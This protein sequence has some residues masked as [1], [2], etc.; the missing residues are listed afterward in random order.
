VQIDTAWKIDF[1]PDTLLHVHRYGLPLWEL[2]HLFFTHSH[3]DHMDV[4]DLL[5]MVP[6][7][8]H[9]DFG[10]EPLN[11]YLSADAAKQLTAQTD[12][13]MLPIELHLLRPFE[14]VHAGAL[15]A[16]PVLAAHNPQE[17]CLF[18]VLEKDGKTVL[19]ASD[20]GPFPEA[21]WEFL[22]TKQFDLVI[23]ECT[24]G[25]RQMHYTG[26]MGLPNVVQIRERLLTAGA[27]TPATPCW[28]THFSHNAQITHDEFV[29]MAA[30]YGIDV[31]YDGVQLTV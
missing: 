12:G 20:T 18:Y 30:P 15:T 31:A 5:M 22:L 10:N 28:I 16:T 8:G 21:T 25:A 29:Q 23:T 9:N 6:P 7:F 17:E 13:R 11:V 19:Y 2:R 4:N 26:H 1:P 3:Q 27:I 24:F 14:P